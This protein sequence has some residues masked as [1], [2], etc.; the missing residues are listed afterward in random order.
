MPR[1]GVGY[2]G[3]GTAAVHLPLSAPLAGLASQ[4]LQARPRNALE[5]REAHWSTRRTIRALPLPGEGYRKVWARLLL[6]G[7]ATSLRRLLRLARQ[8]RL[9][10]PLRQP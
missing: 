10:A 8:H 3:L 5:S 1:V 2:K 9:L 4:A 6:A 7:L